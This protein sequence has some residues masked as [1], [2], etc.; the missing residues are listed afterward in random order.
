MLSSSHES[1]TESIPGPCLCLQDD[2]EPRKRRLRSL[3]SVPGQEGEEG[4][5]AGQSK[6]AA[7]DDTMDTDK[8]KKDEGVEEEDGASK[9]A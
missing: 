8:D 6:D 3:V 9:A 1:G 5:T 4:S 7:A 2:A